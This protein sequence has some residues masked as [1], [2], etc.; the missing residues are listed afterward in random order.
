[1]TTMPETL[2]LQFQE[3]FYKNCEERDAFKEPRYTITEYWKI[4]SS[5]K[6]YKEIEQ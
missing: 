2:P 1:M 6:N 3:D 4:W 5:F